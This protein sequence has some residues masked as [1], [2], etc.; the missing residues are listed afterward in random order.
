M[1]KEHLKISP[2]T[3]AANAG[4]PKLSKLLADVTFGRV[5]GCPA[6]CTCGAWV[7]PDG[8]CPHGH[9]SVLRAKGMV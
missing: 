4:Y 1:T 2:K 5:N 6:C 3:A 7:E 9:P 8:N